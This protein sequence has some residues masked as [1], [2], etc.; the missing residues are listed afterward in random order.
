[1][2]ALPLG[3]GE[4]RR[5]GRR[6]AILAF[7]VMLAPA[8]AVGEA[9]DATVVNMRFIKPLDAELVLGLAAGHELIVT[10]EESVVAGGAGSAVNECLAAAGV[11]LPVANYGLPDRLIQHGS[12][13]EMLADAGLTAAAFGEF[14]RARV[15]RLEA[16][17]PVVRRA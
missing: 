6:I 2:R 4:L 1:M 7:G 16:Q 8:L 3:R 9:L 13:E 17:A 15:A 12:R 11:A 5:Q 10:I 14:V